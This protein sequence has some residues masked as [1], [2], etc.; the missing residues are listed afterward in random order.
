MVVSQVE[1]AQS[2][3]VNS[4]LAVLDISN[5]VVGHV[6]SLQIVQAYQAFKLADMVVRQVKRVQPRQMRYVLDHLNLILVKKS[7]NLNH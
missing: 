1:R 6:Q 3:Q 4:L 7:K 5:Q 2:W